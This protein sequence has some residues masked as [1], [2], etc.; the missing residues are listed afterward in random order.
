MGKGYE[1][2]P[3]GTSGNCVVESGGWQTVEL[4]SDTAGPDRAKTNDGQQRT[5]MS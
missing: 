4:C 2:N 5:P 1:E 3:F